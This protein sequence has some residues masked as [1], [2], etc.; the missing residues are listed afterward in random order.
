MTFGK[1]YFPLRTLKHRNYFSGARS[2]AVAAAAP[3][4]NAFLELANG[5]DFLLLANATDKLQL[6][7]G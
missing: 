7:G 1:Q 3:V 5:T 4:G 2:Q 6:A